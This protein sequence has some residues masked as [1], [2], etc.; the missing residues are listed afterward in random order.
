MTA[1]SREGFKARLRALS[2]RQQIAFMAAL[3][4]RLLPNYGLYAQMTGQGDPGA[5][6]VVLDLAWESL[7]VREARID[8]ARQAEK[9][10]EAEPP[11]DDES[12]GARRAVEVM[13]ALSTLLDALQGETPDAA[14]TV[15]GLSKSG[16]QAFVEMTEGAEDDDAERAAARL[17]AHPLMAD[18]RDFQE[19]VLEAAEAR[20]DREA[21]KAL[22]RLG[23]NDGVS[24]LGLSL[25]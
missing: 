23:R 1:I 15:S 22:R 4:E 17:R 25:E 5:L 19:A 24:N 14:L 20:L 2:R 16:V 12:F 13:M 6:R 9:L 7:M 18:E 8:F 10:S 11:E 3:C 21:L